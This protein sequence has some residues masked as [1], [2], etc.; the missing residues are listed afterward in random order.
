MWAQRSQSAWK[1][2]FWTCGSLFKNDTASHDSLY[3][4]GGRW[5]PTGRRRTRFIQ[6]LRHTGLGTPPICQAQN[7][8]EG[9]VLFSTGIMTPVSKMRILRL[10]HIKVILQVSPRACIPV[11]SFWFESSLLLGV[12]SARRKGE[13]TF[14]LGVA[15]FFFLNR[16]LLTPFLW[17][18]IRRLYSFARTA[19]RKC[20]KP[21]SFKNRNVFSRD[22]GG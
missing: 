18:S 12:D 6:G 14:Y 19:I 20:H 8:P 1:Q 7:P 13:R 21:G 11:P 5:A 17:R 3:L 15:F 4:Q 10:A 2:K 16:F 22:P 9:W